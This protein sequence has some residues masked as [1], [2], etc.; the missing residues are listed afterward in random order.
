MSTIT[1][2]RITSIDFLR[3]SIMIIM[4]LDHVRDYLFADSF[5]YDP[6]GLTKTSG[7]I[8]FT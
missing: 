7:I 5:F 1:K 8:F 3:G 6:L 4:A 2:N